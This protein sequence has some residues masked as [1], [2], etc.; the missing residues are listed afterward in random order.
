MVVLYVVGG[1]LVGTGRLEV[2][3]ELPQKRA[4][5]DVYSSRGSTHYM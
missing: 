1:G 5:P 3:E 2:W 4:I